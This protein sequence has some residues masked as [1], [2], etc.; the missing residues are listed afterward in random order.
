MMKKYQSAITI[1]TIYIVNQYQDLIDTTP[2]VEVYKYMR[3]GTLI[4]ARLSRSSLRV[5]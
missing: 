1:S 3:C 2:I 4:T 5:L